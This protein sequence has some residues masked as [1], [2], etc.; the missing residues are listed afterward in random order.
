MPV[1]NQTAS[2]KPTDH[3]QDS[4]WVFFR[5]GEGGEGA[6]YGIELPMDD[7]M[8]IAACAVEDIRSLEELRLVWSRY[9]AEEPTRDPSFLQPIPLTQDKIC[10]KA[11]KHGVWVWIDMVECVL[12]LSSAFQLTLEGDSETGRISLIETAMPHHWETRKAGSIEAAM[13]QRQ[14]E[15]RLPR[16]A[17]EVLWG[18]PWL[19]FLASAI[20]AVEEKTHLRHGVPEQVLYDEIVSIHKRWLLQP[21]N[22]LDGRCPRECIHEHLEWSH[23]LAEWQYG[24]DRPSRF[25]RMIPDCLTSHQQAPWGRHEA[26]MYFEATRELLD[27]AMDWINTPDA[28][29]AVQIQPQLV[30]AMEAHLNQWLHESFEDGPC[31]SSIIERERGRVPLLED[32]SHGNDCQCPI[33]RWMGQNAVPALVM[34][35]GFALEIDH[36]FAFSLT[37]DREEWEWENEW[38]SEGE[39]DDDEEEDDQFIELDSDDIP[40]PNVAIQKAFTQMLHEAIRPLDTMAESSPS[41]KQPKGI[42]VD[43]LKRPIVSLEK[44][45]LRISDVD[46]E[47]VWEN[48]RVDERHCPGG[49]AGN[50]A[51]TFF[52]AEVIWLMESE[53]LPISRMELLNLR[54][55]DYFRATGKKVMQRCAE[56]LKEMLEELATIKPHWISRIA[57]LQSRIDENLRGR[58]AKSEL[59]RPHES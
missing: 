3:S 59:R 7:A 17:R 58:L 45:E 40:L 11:H 27:Y 46:R 4:A 21:R 32:M 35:D 36:E 33:C 47:T 6:R 13:V 57:D 43:G 41:A 18:M 19:E 39:V 38:L 55:E 20:A 31:P 5:S 16:P 22:D 53:D 37:T 8:S 54:L 2:C 26:I 48:T 51:L 44:N 23:A 50:L 52:F 15:L 49:P 42:L 14:S 10:G 25:D 1:A 24:W 56:S 28:T 12:A 34:M 29:E 9:D 30:E